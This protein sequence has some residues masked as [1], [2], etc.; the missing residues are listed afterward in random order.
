MWLRDGCAAQQPQSADEQL[1][2]AQ[3]KE[4]L[5]TCCLP[6][7]SDRAEADLG[8]LFCCCSSCRIILNE[9]PAVAAAAHLADGCCVQLLLGALHTHLQ[10]QQQQRQQQQQQLT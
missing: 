7:M 1:P 4:Q 5:L 3:D 2:A 6:S 8:T 9:V 10:G